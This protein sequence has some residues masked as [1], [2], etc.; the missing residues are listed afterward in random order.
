MTPLILASR[1]PRRAQL[2]RMLGLHFDVLPSEV[3]ETYRPGEE[4]GEHAERLAREKASAVANARPDAL[5]IGCDTVVVIDGKVL[6]KPR[7]VEDAVRMLMVLQGREHVVAT[8]VAVASN[9]DVSSGVERVNV[10]F[11][12]FDED[13]ARAY[14]A[15]GEPL[16]KAGAYGIQGYGATLVDRIEGDFFAVM[17]LPIVRLVLLLEAQGWTYDFPSVEPGS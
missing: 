2:L 10:R 17:G 9:A 13:F 15:T 7:D 3:D 1:S 5:V 16:D 8:G 11:R 12:G 6:G 4:P 14:V